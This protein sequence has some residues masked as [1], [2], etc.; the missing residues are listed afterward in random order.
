VYSCNKDIRERNDAEG[1]GR[2]KKERKRG[3]KKN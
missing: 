2:K 1:K 3:M